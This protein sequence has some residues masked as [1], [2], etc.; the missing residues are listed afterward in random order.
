MTKGDVMN[1]DKKEVKTLVL[2]GVKKDSHTKTAKVTSQ[3]KE[4]ETNNKF[5]GYNI[6]KKLPFTIKLF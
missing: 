3:K 2:N 1:K 6:T 5:T 4:S